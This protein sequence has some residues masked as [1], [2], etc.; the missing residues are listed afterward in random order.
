MTINLDLKSVVVGAV[1][2]S[3]LPFVTAENLRDLS[4]VKALGGNVTLASI[5]AIATWLVRHEKN[6]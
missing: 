3:A 4:E 1:L 6:D 5:V 2:A